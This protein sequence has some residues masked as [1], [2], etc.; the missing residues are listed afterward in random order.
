MQHLLDKRG[1]GRLKESA[2]RK[3]PYARLTPAQ[4][5]PLQLR[6]AEVSAL[7]T[8]AELLLQAE[9]REAMRIARTR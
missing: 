3:T 7:I 5:V 4:P 2:Q 6:I 1:S 8:S 9:A